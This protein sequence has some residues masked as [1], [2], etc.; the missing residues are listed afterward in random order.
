MA[1]K[2]RGEALYRA[3]IVRAAVT[4]ADTQGIDRLSM[5]RLGEALD[6]EAMSLYHHIPGKPALLDAM[7]DWVFEQIAVPTA[8]EWA[9]GLR[10]RAN[11]Q[12]AALRRHPWALRLLE[13]RSTPGLANLRHHDAV[14]GYLR[15]AGFSLR[16]AGHAYAL[17]DAFVYGFALQEEA[18]PFDAAS[19]PDV[20][21]AMLNSTSGTHFPNLVA[22]MR[23]IVLPGGYDFADE[24]EVGLTLVLDGVSR[25]RSGP[26]G[27]Q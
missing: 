20:A 2:R 21:G 4:V 26:G 25:L 8:E 6:V 3:G 15:A 14:L 17:L 10:E 7:V 24:F 13:S 1:E 22:F 9:E 27:P 12:R 18:L 11:S 23:D 16:A 5:R 19:A